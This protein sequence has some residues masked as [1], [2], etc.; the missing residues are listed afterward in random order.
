M[1][2]LFMLLILIVAIVSCAKPEQEELAARNAATQTAWEK[3][4]CSGWVITANVSGT[5][6]TYHTYQYEYNKDKS[7]ITYKF[8]VFNS[9]GIVIDTAKNIQNSASLVSIVG[10]NKQCFESRF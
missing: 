3:Q 6:G 2:Y 8:Y 1:K 9:N 5:I 4:R 10:Y 7:V